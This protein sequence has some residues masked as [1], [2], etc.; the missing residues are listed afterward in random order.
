ML[1]SDITDM[2]QDK[3]EV[4][5]VLVLNFFIFIFFFSLSNQLCVVCVDFQQVY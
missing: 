5:S 1:N 4:I 2:L 3:V